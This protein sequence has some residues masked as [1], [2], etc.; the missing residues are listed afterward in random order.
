MGAADQRVVEEGHGH[1]RIE[2]SDRPLPAD[3]S[4]TIAEA[5]V[6]PARRVSRVAGSEGDRGP[7]GQ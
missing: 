5:R 4:S 6:F 1:R 7:S 2:L 3:L